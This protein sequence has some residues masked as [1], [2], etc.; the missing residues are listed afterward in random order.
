MIKRS[1]AYFYILFTSFIL[2]AHA[3]IP[4][5]HHESEIFIVNSDC[6]SDKG[7]HNHGSTKHQH[8]THNESNAENCIIQQVVVVRSNQ[9]KVEYNSQDKSKNHPEIQGFKND[10]SKKGLNVPFPKALLNTQA[11]LLSSSYLILACSSIGLRAPP[12]FV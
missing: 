2:L 1:T 3:V 12:Q 4:H 5:H 7:V 6:Q 11:S 9:I 10:L 8:E